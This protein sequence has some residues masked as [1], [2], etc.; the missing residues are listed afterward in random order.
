M[1]KIFRFFLAS[2]RRRRCLLI[3][4]TCRLLQALRDVETEAAQQYSYRLDCLDDDGG[5]DVR[6][7]YLA[8]EDDYIN[9]EHIAN[10][11]ESVIED[12]EFLY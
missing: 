1:Q 10:T 9:C 3:G 4:V 2:G 8:V 7:E 5:S 6:R 11:L 12:L